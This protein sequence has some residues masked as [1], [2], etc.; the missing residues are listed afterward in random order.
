M[1]RKTIISVRILITVYKNVHF[2]KKVLDSIENQS[3]KNFSV[4]ILEDGDS[5][6]VKNFINNLDYN[7]PIDHISQEDIGFRKNKILNKGIRNASED[8]IIFLDEDCMLHPK[9]V[10]NYIK[11]YDEE[12][13][14]FAK[15]VNMDKVT[16]SKL[17]QS[18]SCKPS[19]ISLFLNKANHI[20]DGF[21]FP[22]KQTKPTNKPSLLGCN[23]AI[24]LQILKAINGFD[25]DYEIPGF[26][27]DTDIQ[28]RIQ[29]AGYKFINMK[30]LTIQYHF[31][32][33]RPQRE[34]Q[35]A[36]SK[37]I[38]LKKMEIG[39]VYC[40]NGLLKN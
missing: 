14:L 4:S 27:E 36:K 28:W 19:F 25:E 11:N 24:P 23:M 2:L 39:E 31:F 35:T 6:L 10:E 34:D 30:H 9:F 38:Y 18:T 12:T 37:E 16:S 3:Y 40:K 1:K 13:V 7:F 20:E 5:E 26:G 29:K 33:E 21:Y 22:L 17:L 8:L 32:H 15:R